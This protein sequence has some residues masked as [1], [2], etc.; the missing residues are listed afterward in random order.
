MESHTARLCSA[1]EQ[2]LPSNARRSRRYCDER[3]RNRAHR[4]RTTDASASRQ[5]NAAN[6]HIDKL[7]KNLRRTESTLESTKQTSQKRAER[8]EQLER[9]LGNRDRYIQEQAERNATATRRAATLKIELDNLRTAH[10]AVAS[11]DPAEVEQLRAHLEEG[12]S[13]YREL[14]Q[15]YDAI[16]AG[17]DGAVRERESLQHVVRQWDRLAKRLNE[18]TNGK[19]R[20]EKDQEILST[21]QAFR[22][23][24]G[25]PTK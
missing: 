23:Q 25:K 14:R 17:L 15:Q 5:S 22:K 11:I 9:E 13:A 6:W 3:C 4:R 24:I 8:I 1:C 10:T 12:R 2:P 18:Q 19:P 7:R 21:W 16:S 20:T